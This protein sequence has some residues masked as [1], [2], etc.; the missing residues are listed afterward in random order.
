M[1][2]KVNPFF[3]T[4]TM[5]DY[6]ICSRIR[7]QL[8]S[9]VSAKKDCC[10]MSAG[11]FNCIESNTP[12]IKLINEIKMMAKDNYTATAQIIGHHLLLTI[13]NFQ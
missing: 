4:A 7:T 2:T 9:A 5:P 10:I 8:Y 11:L 12:T 1:N 3:Q 13:V 6:L